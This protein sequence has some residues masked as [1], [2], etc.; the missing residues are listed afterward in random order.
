[1]TYEELLVAYYKYGYCEC[2]EF[3]EFMRIY[4]GD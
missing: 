2:M 1:M 3:P 4:G